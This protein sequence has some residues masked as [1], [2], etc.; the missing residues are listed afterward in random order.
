MVAFFN[1]KVAKLHETSFKLCGKII[2]IAI[3]FN[4]QLCEEINEFN[5]IKEGIKTMKIW[6]LM[7]ME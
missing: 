7:I 3:S 5:A 4:E 6:L 1:H 2:K